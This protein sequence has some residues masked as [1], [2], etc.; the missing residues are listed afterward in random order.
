M[1]S[2]FSIISAEIELALVHV[3]RRSKSRGLVVLIS[4]ETVREMLGH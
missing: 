2:E 4:N 1:A 3:R